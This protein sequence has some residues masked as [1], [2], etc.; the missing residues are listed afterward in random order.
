MIKPDNT[1]GPPHPNESKGYL[2]F[3][4][5]SAF[6]KILLNSLCVNYN[7]PLENDFFFGFLKKKTQSIV[8]KQTCFV[9]EANLTFIQKLEKNP[10]LIDKIKVQKTIS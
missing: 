4:I 7:S 2:S 6:F 5:C 8:E 9:T 1:F 10:K 3:K